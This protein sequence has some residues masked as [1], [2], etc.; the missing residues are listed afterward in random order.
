[1][2]IAL[3][4]AAA[5]AVPD[6]PKDIPESAVK[7]EVR[8]VGSPA[9]QLAVWPDGQGIRVFFQYNDRGHG[10]KSYTTLSLATDGTPQ[11]VLIEGS[12]YMKAP[13]TETYSLRY[14]AATWKNNSEQGTR[15]VTAPSFYLSMAGSPL[16]LALVADAALRNGGAI[17]LLPEGEARVTAVTTHEG[18]TL[19]A[20]TG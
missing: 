7:Y 1:M 15:S 16:D 4:L 11:S 6:L 12:N 9:G 17:A 18:A 10:P 5:S 19:Y 3:L 13:V 8:M 2:L 14:G 20:I